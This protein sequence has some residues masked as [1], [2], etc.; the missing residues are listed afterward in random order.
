MLTKFTRRRT[1]SEDTG[2]APRRSKKLAML[3]L[4]GIVLVSQLLSPLQANAA[5]VYDNTVSPINTLVLSDLST[6]Q[7]GIDVANYM[8]YITGE[9]ASYNACDTTCKA[10]ID[11]AVAS[12][13]PQIYITMGFGIASFYFSQDQ[14]VNMIFETVG[15]DQRVVRDRSSNSTTQCV[16]LLQYGTNVEVSTGI[17]C[18]E[19]AL[20][21]GGEHLTRP[22][23]NT[24]PVIYPSGYEGAEIPGTAG[25][26]TALRPNIVAD[27]NNKRISIMSKRENNILGDYKIYWFITNATFDDPPP[28]PFSL[29]G[30]SEPDNY[31]EFDI[32]TLNETINIQANF[33]D[34]NGDPLEPPEGFEFAPALITLVPDGS[35]Y[36]VDTD[37]MVCDD[38]DYC[39]YTPTEWEDEPCDLLNLGG[40]VANIWH[41]IQVVLG[42]EKTHGNPTGSPF[43][44]F[45]TGTYGFTAVVAAPMSFINSLATPGGCTTIYFQNPIPGGDNMAFTCIRPLLESLGT[46]FTIYQTLILGFTAYWVGVRVLGLIM[47]AKRPQNDRI[48]VHD[49]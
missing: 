44:T 33:V 7:P 5:S 3:L 19:L 30:Y 4:G 26:V 11:D 16:A 47:D 9:G 25:P 23:L 18:N 43:V 2:V 42:I 15:S 45:S 14:S 13:N 41:Y 37:G 10:K 40:C 27:V 8:Y 31:L 39:S 22:Y 36:S 49:L 46:V 32:P 21:S 1:Q 38:N 34:V 17:G 48:E 6:S 28:I 24:L 12:E 29:E 35:I 20:Y